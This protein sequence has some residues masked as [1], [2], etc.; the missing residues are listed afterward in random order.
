MT[1]PLP[2][3]TLPRA[4]FGRARARYRE[5]VRPVALAALVLIAGLIAAGRPARGAP[6]APASHETIARVDGRMADSLASGRIPAA[7]ALAEDA[8]ALRRLGTPRATASFLDS[9][10]LRFFGAGTPEAWQAATGFFR[11]AL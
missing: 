9:L 10:G 5:A 2:A 1:G 6:R 3:S 7:A 4:L 8:L 11:R